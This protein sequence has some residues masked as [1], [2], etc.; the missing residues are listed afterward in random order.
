MTYRS[1]GPGKF[2][3]IVDSHVYTMTN[4]GGADEEESYPEGGGWYGLIR[5]DKGTVDRLIEIAQEEGDTLTVEELNE[6]HKTEAGGGG[7][8]LFER[9]DGIVE[10]DWFESEKA[11]DKAWAHIV[12][13]FDDMRSEEEDLEENPMRLGYFSESYPAP[14]PLG[15][16]AKLA[17]FGGGALLATGLIYYFYTKNAAAASQAAVLSSPL[18]QAAQT[19]LAAIQGDPNYCTSVGQVGSEVNT[20]VHDFKLA[21]NQANPGNPVPIGTG[22]FEPVVAAA[23]AQVLGGSGPAGC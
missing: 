10:A 22:K 12:A 8:I 14:N 11:L 17:V 2:Y 20:A 4:D 15:K 5:F 1:Y 23:L 21:W 9:S 19:A 6:L 16:G 3:T 13:E 7:V 18:G